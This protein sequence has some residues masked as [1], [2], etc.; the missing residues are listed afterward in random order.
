MSP[1]RPSLWHRRQAVRRV[2]HQ[3]Q[4]EERRM[5]RRMSQP[6]RHEGD[7]SYVQKQATGGSVTYVRRLAPVRSLP[8]KTSVTPSGNCDATLREPV[9][10]DYTATGAIRTTSGDGLSGRPAFTVP[11]SPP[12]GPTGLS[13]TVDADGSLTLPRT[14]LATTPSPAT[15]S[16]GVD[17]LRGSQ[18]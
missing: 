10:T 2:R 8:W 5:D 9:T 14:T 6:A 11:A 17:L 3:I 12:S 16:C 1:L 7:R 15:A 18:R 13:A 4:V